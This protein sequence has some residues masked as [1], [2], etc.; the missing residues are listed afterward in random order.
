MVARLV[1]QASA[2]LVELEGKAGYDGHRA[3][4]PAVVRRAPP[5]RGV[6]TRPCQV[7]LS[8]NWPAVFAATPPVVAASVPFASWV[9]TFS[10]SWVT[11]APENL[12][13][14][15]VDS[16]ACASEGIRAPRWL[17]V[18][19]LAVRLAWLLAALAELPSEGTAHTDMPRRPA[20]QRAA[21]QPWHQEGPAGPAVGDPRVAWQSADPVSAAC[22]YTCDGARDCLATR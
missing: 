18:P 2:Q 19:S 14:S 10:T 7:V 22:R 15:W 21:Q 1:E 3:S 16:G 9:A 12:P 13:P 5:W 20:A 8:R 11:S 6:A 17:P 4:P